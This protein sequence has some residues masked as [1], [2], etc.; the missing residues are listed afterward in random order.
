MSLFSFEVLS[1][2]KPE[3]PKLKKCPTCFAYLLI[4]AEVCDMCQQKVRK[5]DKWGIAQKPVDR[6]SYVRCLLMWCLFGLYMWWLFFQD[7]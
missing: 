5:I 2:N 3:S 1:K 4:H 7:K 6:M